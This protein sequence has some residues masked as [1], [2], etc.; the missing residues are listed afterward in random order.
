MRFIAQMK[1]PRHPAP[2]TPFPLVKSVRRHKAAAP[3]PRLPKRRLDRSGLQPRIGHSLPY[4][5]V[6]RP[7]RHQSPTHPRKHRAR[8]AP[9]N[10]RCNLCWC[11]VIARLKV[12]RACVQRQHNGELSRVN[13][14]RVSPAHGSSMSGCPRECTSNCAVDAQLPCCGP[15]VCLNPWTCT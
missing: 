8:L 12:K 9:G 10:N 5:F 7:S 3:F 4:F 6:L 1:M 11:N 15:C 2:A 14:T 13:R